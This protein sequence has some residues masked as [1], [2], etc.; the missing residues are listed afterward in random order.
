MSG[1]LCDTCRHMVGTIEPQDAPPYV[2]CR[3]RWTIRKVKKW[4]EC[5][6]YERTRPRTSEGRR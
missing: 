3:K 1:W 4:D 2:N 6:D 5:L